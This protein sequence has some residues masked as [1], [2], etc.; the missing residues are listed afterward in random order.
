MAG[1]ATI[2]GTQ[3]YI[4]GIGHPRTETTTEA[5]PAMLNA[6]GN[7]LV[8]GTDPEQYPL[9]PLSGFRL[10][11]DGNSITA[12]SG[13]PVTTQLAP[14]TDAGW[15]TWAMGYTSLK[16]RWTENQAVSANTTTQRRVAL[17]NWVPNTTANMLAFLE[18]TNSIAGYVTGGA[19]ETAAANLAFADLL[20]YLSDVRSYGKFKRI[21]LGT[22][23]P[24]NTTA[25]RNAANDLYNRQV[26]ELCASDPVYVLVDFWDAMVDPT[27][28]TMFTKA[29][30]LR[31]DDFLHPTPK[32]ARA[33]GLKFSQA[34][35]NMELPKSNL[36]PN[37]ALVR[38]IQS[39]ALFINSNP[40]FTGGDTGSLIGSATGTVKAGWRAGINTGTMTCAA[41]V[42]ADAEGIGNAQRI[43]VSGAALNSI[44]QIGINITEAIPYQV[45]NDYIRGLA[46]IRWSG[47]ANVKAI[48]AELAF[49]TDANYTVQ[50]QINTVATI[51]VADYDQAD[52]AV[53]YIISTPAS[54]LNGGVAANTVLSI[55]IKVLF[56]AASGAITLDV[57]RAG[58]VN[59]GQTVT[60]Y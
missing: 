38:S 6:D 46:S 20:A 27:S 5:A 1:S 60:Q 25:A 32:G 40:L 41:S 53:P 36:V 11:T 22:V 8:V 7:A 44:A 43:T 58:M 50:G 26:R 18:G 59:L 47:A 49:V 55:A 17:P 14:T 10:A 23:P 24:R 56:G 45:A 2:T 13:G 29:N 3:H 28:A 42:V 12:V 52:M 21:F 31:S 30:Y 37:S 34:V 9:T 33:M 16:F 4:G 19:T 15:V 51:A 57:S 35:A 39:D 48:Y 54:L